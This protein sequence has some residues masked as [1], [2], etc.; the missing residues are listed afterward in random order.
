MMGGVMD[1]M[2]GMGLVSVVGLAALVLVAAA[3]IKYL[4]FDKRKDQ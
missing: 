2:W 4:F 1:G 3:A